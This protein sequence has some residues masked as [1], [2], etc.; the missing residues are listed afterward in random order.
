[1]TFA[2]AFYGAVDVVL[3]LVMVCTF[4]KI[5]RRESVHSLRL[6]VELMLRC[7]VATRLYDD[8]RHDVTSAYELYFM[9]E[10]AYVL[11]ACHVKYVRIV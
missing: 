1:V 11:A 4:F 9:I 7:E 10:L 3:P 6:K 2:W 5:E 8:T